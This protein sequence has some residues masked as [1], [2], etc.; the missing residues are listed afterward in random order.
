MH[1]SERGNSVYSHFTHTH[2]THTHTHTHTRTHTHSHT[3]SPDTHTHVQ[4]TKVCRSLG[5]H[6]LVYT[7]WIVTHHSQISWVTTRYMRDMYLCDTYILH[8]WHIY[9]RHIYNEIYVSYISSWTW[10]SDW[11]KLVWRIPADSWCVIRIRLVAAHRITLQRTLQ[12]PATP[13]NTLQHIMNTLNRDVSFAI[14]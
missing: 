12:R 8:V 13:C 3:H 11:G 2:M 14:D 4:L 6:H 10:E 1:T 9:V 5:Y 7:R